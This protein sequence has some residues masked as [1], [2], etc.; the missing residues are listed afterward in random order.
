MIE[1]VGNIFYAVS[2]NVSL[3]YTIA[4]T[5]NTY[6][7]S[8][9]LA[10]PDASTTAAGAVVSNSITIP[11]T[12]G[13]LSDVNVGLNVTHTYP[14]DLIIAINSQ[15]N[16]TQ[17]SVWNNACAGDDNFNVTLSDGSPAFT[18]TANMTGTFAPS[19]PLSAFNGGNAS[20]TWTLLAA[21]FSNVDTGT[22]NSWSVQVCTQI[23]TLRTEDFGLDQFVLYPNPGNGNFNIRFDSSSSNEI[24]VVVHDIRG[25]EI[26]SRNYQNTGTFEQNVQLS[27]VQS[28]VYLVTVKDGNRK[29]VKKLVIE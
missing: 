16:A 9:P 15:G 21:D 22:I 23:L 20:G 1:A 28:G 14:Q 8:T 29:E 25:R 2:K 18:C 5:C 19:S 24:G 4:T 17:V 10:V 3:G 11:V 13:V 27:S 6:T 7:N 12:T 26:F